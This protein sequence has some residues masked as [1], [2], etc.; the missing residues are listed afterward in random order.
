MLDLEVTPGIGL[1]KADRR[2]G[3]RLRALTWLSLAALALRFAFIWANSLAG[4]SLPLI[5][6][7]GFAVIFTTFSLLHA[8][9]ILGW[10]RAI[11]FLLTCVVVSWC[12]EEVG[13]ATGA[14]YGAY[15]YSNA[16]GVKVGAVPA[17]I[18]FGWFVMVYASWIVAHILLQGASDPSSAP[19]ILVRAY[20]ASAVITAWDAVMD[21]GMAARGVW[22]WENGGAYFG[23][24]L[25]N[26]V[27]WMATTFTVYVAI[28]VIFRYVP[29]RV[30]P[31]SRQAYVGIPAIAYSFVAL[32]H[33][34]IASRPELHVVAAF[35]MCLAAS[36]ALFRLLLVRQPLSL[37][38][39]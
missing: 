2:Q 27:G 33:L 37:P 23:V 22:T 8:A 14:V 29:G 7:T 13:I 25:Q 39:A 30:L 31:E 36:L 10:R 26:Y 21:P 34:L 20:A 17:L 18:P 5:S 9:S 24:P 38:R 6:G 32:D 3:E 12:F 16:L 11:L 15:H 35:S 28:A 1:G 19:G 4:T